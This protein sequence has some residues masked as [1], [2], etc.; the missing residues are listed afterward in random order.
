MDKDHEL[1]NHY[2]M[3]KKNGRI[4]S[5]Y[6][7]MHMYVVSL[8]AIN[9]LKKKKGIEKFTDFE[10]SC[11]L[12]KNEADNDILKVKEG[13]VDYYMEKYDNLNVDDDLWSLA[14]AIEFGEQRDR[15]IKEDM[16][17]E[18]MEKGIEKGM[19]TIIHQMIHSRYHIDAHDWIETLTEEDLNK[20]SHL[21]FTC[22]TFD[23]LKS[24]LCTH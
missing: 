3:M 5:E 15:V 19:Q 16:Y 24:K 11:Y 21:L 12:F 13:T 2:Q 1:I 23:E 17:E 18:G 20:I 10:K 14:W 6:N 4:M 9:K 8:P 7:L 22:D